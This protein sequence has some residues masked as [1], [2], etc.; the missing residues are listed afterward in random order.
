MVK[1]RNITLIVILIVSSIKI[2]AQIPDDP[3]KDPPPLFDNKSYTPFEGN[4]VVTIGGYDNFYLGVQGAEPHGSTNPL[5]PAE[6]FNAWNTN[7]A[8]RTN[9]AINWY[10]SVPPFPGY[11]IR[12]DPLTAYDADG[13]LYYMSM[14]GSSILGAVV[15]K[16]TNNGLN[17]SSPVVA[18]S[19]NDKCWMA[20][21]QTNG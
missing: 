13:N 3:T 19:G 18:V 16:S 5:K 15:I 2:F 11:T 9:D 8:Y 20:A 17:W 6:N 1:S 10:G 12:G 21:D 14:Y 4:A 7:Y